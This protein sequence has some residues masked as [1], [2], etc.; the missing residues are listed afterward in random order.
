MQYDPIRMVAQAI[1]DLKLTGADD[2]RKEEQM[3]IREYLID[4]TGFDFIIP[5]GP[6]DIVGGV[7]KLGCSLNQI[8]DDKKVWV[9]DLQLSDYE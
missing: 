4:L 9:Q 6:G 1:E 2:V 7:R 3:K 5:G 8:I